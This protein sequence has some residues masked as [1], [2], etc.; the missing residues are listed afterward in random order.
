[1][2]LILATSYKMCFDYQDPTGEMKVVVVSG[3]V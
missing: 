1:M 3:R 2:G